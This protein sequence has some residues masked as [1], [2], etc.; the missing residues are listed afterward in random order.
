MLG[1]L[2]KAPSTVDTRAIDRAS[3]IVIEML[4]AAR[5][6]IESRLTDRGASL[7]IIPRDEYITI[8]PEFAY[9]AGQR[10]P[11]GNPYDS[12]AVRG[13]G[14]ILSQRATAT[15]EE[16]LLRL[17][18]DPFWAE[19]ITHHEFAHAIMNLGFTS[20]DWSRWSEIYEMARL[21]QT[22]P[23]TFA[24]TNADEYWAELSQSY[25]GVN[26]EIGGPSQVSARDPEAFTLLQEIYEAR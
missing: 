24:M 23:G 5:R 8:L 4:A 12:F 25:F 2:I 3:E 6:D 14:G 11:N 19:S 15:S 18:S 16:N 22:F 1:V 7:V 26:N 10:D 9:L 21:K 13:A 20:G 17:P